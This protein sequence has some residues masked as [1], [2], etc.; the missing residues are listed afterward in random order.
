MKPS[1]IYS[2]PITETSYE[3]WDILHNY[4]DYYESLD[5]YNIPDK[6]NTRVASHAIHYYSADCERIWDLSYLSFDSKPFMIIQRAGRGGKDYFESFVTDQNLYFEAEKYLCSLEI[7]EDDDK[8]FEFDL[9]TDYERIGGFYNSHLVQMKPELRK[10][11][12]TGKTYEDCLQIF[13]EIS[14]FLKH[15][16]LVLEKPYLH[17]PK[18]STM[19][20]ILAWL[21]LQHKD[22]IV[23]EHLKTKSL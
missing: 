23:D 15:K 2:M 12:E 13:N 6:A 9:N 18:G 19:H 20:I 17:F 5:V 10:F 11:I 16:V 14:N 3:S 21:D 1:Q 8:P 4:R 22:F 7:R